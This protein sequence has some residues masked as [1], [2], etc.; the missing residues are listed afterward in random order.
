MRI[1]F[2]GAFCC[3]L[4]RPHLLPLHVTLN[5]A[6]SPPDISFPPLAAHHHGSVEDVTRVVFRLDSAQSR[7]VGSV[8]GLLPIRL[9]GIALT[10][11]VSIGFSNR[12]YLLV[13]R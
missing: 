7:V 1:F 9:V 3:W 6:Q 5:P 8:E 12:P 2:L 4:A 10:S 13:F 11:G